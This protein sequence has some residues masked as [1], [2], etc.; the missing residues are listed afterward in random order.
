MITSKI[1]GGEI[2]S[3]KDINEVIE[4]LEKEGKAKK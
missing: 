1:D 2:I 4:L 3:V